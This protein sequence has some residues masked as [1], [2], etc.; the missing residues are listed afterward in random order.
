MGVSEKL[1]LQKKFLNEMEQKLK[2]KSDIQKV[3]GVQTDLNEVKGSL[4]Q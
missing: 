3:D 4:E 2:A 1:R